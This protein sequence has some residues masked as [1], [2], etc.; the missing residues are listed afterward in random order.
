MAEALGAHVEH[1]VAVWR[2]QE[3]SRP[4]LDDNELQGLLERIEAATRTLDALR[5][6]LERRLPLRRD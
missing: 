3:A 5:L 4:E 6:R 1:E 2:D